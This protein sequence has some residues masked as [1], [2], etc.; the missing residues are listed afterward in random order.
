MLPP[1]LELLELKVD[2][3]AP[4]KDEDLVLGQSIISVQRKDLYIYSSRSPQK[5]CVIDGS[6]I[7]WFSVVSRVQVEKPLKIEMHK[8]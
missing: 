7:Y 3:A 2:S 1:Y 5:A 4:A 8:Y 6:H